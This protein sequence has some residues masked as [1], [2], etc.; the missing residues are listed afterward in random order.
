VAISALTKPGPSSWRRRRGTMR[1]RVTAPLSVSSR[2]RSCFALHPNLTQ[3]DCTGAVRGVSARRGVSRA[4][5]PARDVGALHHV[6]VHGALVLAAMG[7]LRLLRVTELILTVLHQQRLR[8]AR[9]ELACP[10][11]VHRCR[12]LERL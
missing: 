4:G 11:S 10:G 8:Q 6:P 1:Q 7:L 3:L 5:A 2:S 9:R 12:C